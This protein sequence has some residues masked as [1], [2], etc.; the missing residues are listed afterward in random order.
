V[1]PQRSD[2]GTITYLVETTTNLITGVWTNTG[3]A[4]VGTNVTGG[5]LDFVTNDVDTV[6]NKNFI[7][8]KIEE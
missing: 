7:R 1:H 6:R 3:V 5:T 2:D 8:L 4:A